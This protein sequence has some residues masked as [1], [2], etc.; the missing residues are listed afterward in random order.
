[1]THTKAEGEVAQEISYEVK[2]FIAEKPAKRKTRMYSIAAEKAGTGKYDQEVGVD[3][4]LLT[5]DKPLRL[6][7]ED[8]GTWNG[9]YDSKMETYAKTGLM[10][11]VNPPIPL[12]LEVKK[13]IANK[14]TPMDKNDKVNAVFTVEDPVEENIIGGRSA[15]P[16]SKSGRMTIAFEVT[17]LR[18]SKADAEQMEAK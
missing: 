11:L 16:A 9:Y 12:R 6:Y 3:K 13:F 17:L 18:L 14:E 10:K 7:V 5:L 15:S 1:L 2:L 4:D 8:N